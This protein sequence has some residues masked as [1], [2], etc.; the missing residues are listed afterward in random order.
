M[1][2]LKK[3]IIGIDFDNT[4]VSY[5]ELI[6]SVA[7]K[8]GLISVGVVK[9]K[10]EIRD[11]IRELPDGEIEWQRLQAFVYGKGMKNAA[12]M[13]GVTDFFDLCKK[14]NAPR[15]I[16]SH[17]TQFASMDLERVDL[18]QTALQW[19]K[20]NKFF[21]K[22]GFGLAL[23]NVYFKSTRQEKIDCIKT[24]RC[25]HFIDDLE[26]TFLEES[27]PAHV[28]KI[29]LSPQ[30]TNINVKNIK[31]CRSWDQISDYFFGN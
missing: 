7:R 23:D 17:K 28:E 24:L 3:R 1:Q 31:V 20:T 2:S 27:F 16:V 9:N 13:D 25:S 6:Y 4:I 21:S 8:R 15:F 26:E 30:G 10:K 5:N 22:D 12:L 14:L 29:L 11:T 18:R 19:M